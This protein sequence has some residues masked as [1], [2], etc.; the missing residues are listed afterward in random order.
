MP[1]ETA[2]TSPV[3]N[4]GALLRSK[5]GWLG[6]D[7][8]S[9]SIKLAQVER[10]G[11]EYRI[12]ARWTLPEE[13]SSLLSQDELCSDGMKTRFSAIKK[14]RRLFSGQNCAA[15]LPMSLVDIRSFSIPTGEPDELR[16]MVGEELA[17]ELNCEPAELAFDYWHSAEDDNLES[18]LTRVSAIAIPKVLPS[19]LA[20]NLFAGGLVCQN[21]NGMPCA[22]AR[23]VEMSN[24]SHSEESVVVLDLGY[25]SPQMVLVKEGQPLF[26][27]TLRDSGLQSLM[28]P[29]ESALKISPTECQHLLVQY[30]LSITGQPPSVASQKTMRLI[31]GPL[32][33]LIQE[34]RRTLDYIGRQFRAH[35]PQRLCLLG[36]GALIKNMPEY[37]QQNVSLPTAAWQLDTTRSDSSDAFYGVA[38]ALSSLAWDND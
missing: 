38:A 30:G 29:L 28:N 3:A 4:H 6:I 31:A 20:S 37:L 5:R 21:L 36:G 24:A 32:Q 19:K 25:S 8:G 27:R 22:L 26:A 16:R 17:A 7:I 35:P 14:L 9:R 13:S 12:S 1:L 33:N 23:A 2:T 11:I 18:G 10:A 34:I 15:V